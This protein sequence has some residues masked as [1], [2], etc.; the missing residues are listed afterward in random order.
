MVRK[1]ADHHEDDRP[2]DAG[3]VYQTERLSGLSLRHFVLTTATLATY[4]RA[5]RCLAR[6]PVSW[7]KPPSTSIVRYVLPVVNWALAVSD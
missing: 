1:R 2:F 7:R 3:Y 5:S 6:L 4:A